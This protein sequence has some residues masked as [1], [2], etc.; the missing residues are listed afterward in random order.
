MK[1]YIKEKEQR[2]NT[3]SRKMK[4]NPKQTE[5]LERKIPEFK[6]LYCLNEMIR[7]FEL[8]NITIEIIQNKE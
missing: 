4:T 6:K 7:R 8:K 5:L 3:L 2:L 1:P